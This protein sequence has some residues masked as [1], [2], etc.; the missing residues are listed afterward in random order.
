MGWKDPKLE[1]KKLNSKHAQQNGLP[2]LSIVWTL[3]QAV[4]AFDGDTSIDKKET[5]SVLST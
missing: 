5:R 2:F 3:L 4:D 1:I